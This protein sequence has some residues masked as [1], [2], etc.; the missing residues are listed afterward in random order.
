MCAVPLHRE[1]CKVEVQTL[2][3]YTPR[4]RRYDFCTGCGWRPTEP[5]VTSRGS[6]KGVGP[7]TTWNPQNGDL[8]ESSVQ[9]LPLMKG[10]FITRTSSHSLLQAT[11]KEGGTSSVLKPITPGKVRRQSPKRQRQYFHSVVLKYIWSSR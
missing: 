3:M 9:S 4:G 7:R 8:V 2:V 10:D 1:M 11:W 6:T 5:H